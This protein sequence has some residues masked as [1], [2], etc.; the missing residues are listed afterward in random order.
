[1][2]AGRRPAGAEDERRRAESAGAP[3]AGAVGAAGTWEFVKIPKNRK[4]NE[5]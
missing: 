2:D 3:Q 4:T 1:M 5:K